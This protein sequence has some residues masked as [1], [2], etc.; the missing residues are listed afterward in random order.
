MTTILLAEDNEVVREMLGERLKL[1]GFN[2]ITVGNGLEA[3]EFVRQQ[4]P[5]LIMLDMSMP[6]M[7]GWRTA[8]ALEEDP[9]TRN[10][11]VIAVT[12]HALIGDR[13]KAIQAGCDVYV[14]KPVDFP[15]LL[16]KIE[17][18]LGTDPQE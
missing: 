11:P 13:Q 18:L 10:I 8:R 16:R 14:T 1:H 9:L 2:V 3:L 7:D 4:F 5:D 12:A 17:E 6:V 15:N